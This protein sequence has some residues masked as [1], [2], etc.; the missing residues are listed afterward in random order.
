ML[1]FFEIVVGLAIFA[2]VAE[3]MIFYIVW[4]F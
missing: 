4:G 2:M 1:K 3:A